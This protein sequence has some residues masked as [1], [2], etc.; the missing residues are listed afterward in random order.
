MQ[1]VKFYSQI[2][3][4][5]NNILFF[6]FFIYFIQVTK[7]KL[8]KL[9]YWEKK[10]WIYTLSVEENSSQIL[11]IVHKNVFLLFLQICRQWESFTYLQVQLHY[12]GSGG[13]MD[14]WTDRWTDRHK[15]KW[16]N[17]FMSRW[18]QGWEDGCSTTRTFCLQ[19]VRKSGKKK[20]QY[21]ICH[22]TEN[23]YKRFIPFIPY[24]P[25]GRAFS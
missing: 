8:L 6:F 25:E 15:G 5:Q 17:Y 2:S 24:M 10:I 4:P 19:K 3:S 7:K 22:S 23:G 14:G 9:W 20:L 21:L 11:I 13:W 16:R 12:S 18:L 1:W